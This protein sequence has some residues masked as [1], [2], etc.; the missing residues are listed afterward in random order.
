MII[1]HELSLGMES[2]LDILNVEYRRGTSHV[3]PLLL[4]DVSSAHTLTP[5]RRVLD[6]HY[7]APRTIPFDFHHDSHHHSPDPTQKVS[8]HGIY[9]P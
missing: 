5:H 1:L 4:V 8:S 2:Y 6:S 3:K 9:Q 7:E